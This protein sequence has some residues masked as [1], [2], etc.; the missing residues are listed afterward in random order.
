MFFF[1]FLFEWESALEQASWSRGRVRMPEREDFLKKVKRM[2]RPRGS[3][4]K[5]QRAGQG[6]SRGRRCVRETERA[7][8]SIFYSVFAPRPWGVGRNS[9]LR[10]VTWHCRPNRRH[11]HAHA[12][13]RTIPS[14]TPLR[15]NKT[16]AL[17]TDVGLVSP[18]RI[19]FTFSMP[20]RYRVWLTSTSHAPPHQKQ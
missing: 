6:R 16:I 11:S 19:S 14:P 17:L 13:Q 9:R 8:E 18:F 5:F 7:T 1:L 2:N 15:I 10:K 4:K 20:N 3:P 12:D